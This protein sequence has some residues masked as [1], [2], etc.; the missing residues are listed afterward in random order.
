MAGGDTRTTEVALNAQRHLLRT[1]SALLPS[2]L[3]S[4][5]HHPVPLPKA[6]PQ[7]GGT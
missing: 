2:G 3:L 6:H 1:L 7:V 4:L 5:T